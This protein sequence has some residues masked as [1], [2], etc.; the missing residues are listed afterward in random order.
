MIS[1][2]GGNFGSTIIPGAKVLFM[3]NGNTD[4]VNQVDCESWSNS[5]IQVR[6]PESIPDYT[7]ASI[8]VVSCET[9]NEMDYLV[10]VIVP[11]V[12]LS[13]DFEKGVSLSWHHN[14]GVGTNYLIYR[15][16]STEYEWAEIGGTL[17]HAGETGLFIDSDVEGETIYCYMVGQEQLHEVGYSFEKCIETPDLLPQAFSLVSAIPNPFNPTTSISFN[18]PRGGGRVRI[19]VHSIDGRELV[20]L[21]E[22]NLDSGEYQLEWN[23][24]SSSGLTL[25]SGVYLC[26]M[27]ARGFDDCM[28]LILLK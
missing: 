23:G 16:A 14:S 19:S 7:T 2:E 20:V 27:S 15:K 8:Q 25:T 13:F 4:E 17:V 28:K 5:S 12:T 3:W 22:G 18:V 9:S 21:Y 6:I 11:E 1:I 10:P 26:R 24:R